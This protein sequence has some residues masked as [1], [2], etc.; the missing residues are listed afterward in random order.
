MYEWE[1]TKNEFFQVIMSFKD[2]KNLSA[3]EKLKRKVH[4]INPNGKRLMFVVKQKEE[5]CRSKMG[6][7]RKQIFIFCGRGVYERAHMHL[8][9]YM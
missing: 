3:I 6:R 8:S 4:G 2:R 1:M 5:F 9:V 7:F